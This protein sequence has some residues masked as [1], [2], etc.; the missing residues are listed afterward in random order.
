MVQLGLR[1]LPIAVKD[2]VIF[3]LEQMVDQGIIVPELEPSGSLH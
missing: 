3:K 1:R 2:K